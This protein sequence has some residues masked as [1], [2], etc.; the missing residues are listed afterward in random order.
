MKYVLLYPFFLFLLASCSPLDIDN[1][2][3]S[4]TIDT[5][6]KVPIDKVIYSPKT[7]FV[8][9]K[10]QA[11]CNNG[12]ST[13]TP[14]ASLENDINIKSMFKNL[15]GEKK[16]ICANALA[17]FFEKSLHDTS[18]A[19]TV[20]NRTKKNDVDFDILIIGSGIHGAILARNLSYKNP[21]LKI[22]VIDK[23]QHPAS[24]FRTH[25]FRLNS[26]SGSNPQTGV[27]YNSNYFPL[28]P[29]SIVEHADIEKK[30]QKNFP[31]ARQLW[32]QV[33]FNLFASNALFYFDTT[34]KKIDKID[35]NYLITLAGNNALN[36]PLLVKKVVVVSGL[37]S[38][39]MPNIDDKNWFVTQRD[40]L[41]SFDSESSKIPLVLNYDELFEINELLLDQGTSFFEIF[42]NKKIAV[43]G[44]GDSG[45]IVLEFLAGYA[46]K[47][48]YESFGSNKYASPAEIIWYGQS[49]KNYIS[50]ENSSTTKG[51]YKYEGFKKIYNG[52]TF[53]KSKFIFTPIVH[54][55][56]SI[57]QDIGDKIRV[58]YN[59]LSERVDLV[60]TAIG[61]EHDAKKFLS[62]TSGF[63]NSK[64]IRFEYFNYKVH[65]STIFS[66]SNENIAQKI[67]GINSSCEQIFIVGT[68]VDNHNLSHS[69]LFV[70]SLTKNNVSIE[71]LAPLTRAFSTYLISSF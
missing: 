48:S 5:I 49:L 12:A 11:Q 43:I 54:K 52:E 34:I 15:S 57:E 19:I 21:A 29:I 47:Q 25:S 39:I 64:N 37:G 31:V 28:S 41:A 24:H 53:N 10:V 30:G 23:E 61:Y 62:N 27:D 60:I 8:S 56:E 9:E 44:A 36:R 35:D 7:F 18:D 1:S 22:L 58:N 4:N 68:A 3:S 14:S 55:V 6:V 26:P 71:V 42:K 50:F 45:K 2:S 32:N 40:L 63:M 17:D 51:R 33:I 20:V 13:F 70:E 16:E 66:A 46:P 69:R 59:S 65:K 38:V 67:C